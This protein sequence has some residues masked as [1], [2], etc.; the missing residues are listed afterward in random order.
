VRQART[1]RSGRGEGGRLKGRR[2]SDLA[3]FDEKRALRCASGGTSF[4]A[5]GRVRA[6]PATLDRTPKPRSDHAWVPDDGP[7]WRDMAPAWPPATVIWDQRERT[8]R[9][10]VVRRSRCP[11]GWPKVSQV[12][13]P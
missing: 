4:P 8:E 6:A 3:S 7:R 13:D 9:T 11:A 1:R 2:P 5:L 12:T 10:P